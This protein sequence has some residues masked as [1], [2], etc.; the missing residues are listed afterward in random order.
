MDY[1]ALKDTDLFDLLKKGD[2]NAFQEVYFRHWR[3]LLLIAR[4]KLPPT[5]NPEDLVQDLFVKLWEQRESINIT[6]LGAYLHT[7]LRNAVI[8]LYRK[9]LLHERYTAETQAILFSAQNTEEEIE[10][11]DLISSV[12]KELQSMPEKTHRIFRLSRLEYKSVT[13]I[14]ALLSIPERTIEYHIRIAVKK[15]RLVLKDYLISPVILLLC[16][17]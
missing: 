4:D 3:K 12:E 10:L 16:L 5:D 9:R 6:N 2:T 17:F 7:A 14:A 15:L 11:N 8:N 1:S 13:E